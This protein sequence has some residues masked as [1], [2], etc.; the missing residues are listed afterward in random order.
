[1][2][3]QEADGKLLKTMDLLFPR[4]QRKIGG[5]GNRKVV[6]A[7]GVL[8]RGWLPGEVPLDQR[9]TLPAGEAQLLQIIDN[10]GWGRIAGLSILD[11]QPNYERP[12]RIVQEIKLGEQ[13]ERERRD[14]AAD[15]TLKKEFVSLFDELRRLRAGTVDVEVRHNAPFRLILER[16]P[17]E[18]TGTKPAA[19]GA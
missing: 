1:V 8:S 11:G 13:P 2:G 4:A 17:A 15:F 6:A 7:M 18:L 14:I 19:E 3:N 9:F 5:V 12:P 16:G 10:L